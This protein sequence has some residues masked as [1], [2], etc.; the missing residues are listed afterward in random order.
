M[1]LQRDHNYFVLGGGA[2]KAGEVGEGTYQINSLH[3]ALLGRNWG[4]HVTLIKPP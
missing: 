2:G 4:I 1:D 3:L